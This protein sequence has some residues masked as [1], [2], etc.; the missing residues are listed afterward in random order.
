M[1]QHTEGLFE[2]SAALS[3]YFLDAVWSLKDLECIYDLR[4]DGLI[5]GIEVHHDGVPGRR[6]LELQKRFFWEGLHV[7]FTGDTAILAPPLIAE[8]AH[9][10]EMVDIMR[11]VLTTL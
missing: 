7:K 8:R 9:V 3:D 11:R 2:K 6:G 10:D 5:A 4:G 1:D